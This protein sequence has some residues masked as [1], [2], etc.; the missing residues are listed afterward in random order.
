MKTRTLI[1]AGMGSF[2]LASIGQL[3]ASLLIKAL[4]ADL[5]APL[6]GV[7]GSLWQGGV[8]RV[9][10]QGVQI[11]NLQW[12]LHPAAL[13]TGKLAADLR[14]NLVQGGQFE[15]NCAISISGN[16][17]CSGVNLTAIPAQALAPY[18]QGFMI[19]PLSGVFQASLHSLEWGQQTLPRLSGHGE[20]QEAGIQMLPQ[21]FGAYTAVISAGEQGALNIT[22]ASAPGAAFTVDGTVTVQQ[23]GQYQSQLTLTPGNSI[24]AGSK[25]FLNSFLGAPQTDGGYRIQEQ[26]QLPAFN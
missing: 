24:D 5:A 7:N 2:L 11:N 6:Q 18:L 14:G 13:L 20:W 3:P 17:A 16:L 12:D 25:Q 22:L 9:N 10:W 26:G 19:P 15:G 4:P 21:R 8:S 23:D 1:L